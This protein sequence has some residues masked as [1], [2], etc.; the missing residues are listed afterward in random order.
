MRAHLLKYIYSRRLCC[1][2]AKLWSSL[3]H[4]TINH[5]QLHLNTLTQ[6]QTKNKFLIRL[7]R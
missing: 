3:V 7:S 5:L 1:G 2:D 4:F 6:K